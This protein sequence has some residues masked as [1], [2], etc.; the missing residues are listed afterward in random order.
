LGHAA[1]TDVF[2]IPKAHFAKE[3]LEQGDEGW[4]YQVRSVFRCRECR[5]CNVRKESTGFPPNEWRKE[6]PPATLEFWVRFPNERNHTEPGKTG[7]PC[8]KVPGSSR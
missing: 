8:V 5:K 2:L 4:W 7:A 3:T 1:G 6:Q